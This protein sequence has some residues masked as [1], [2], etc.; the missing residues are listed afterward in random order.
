MLLSPDTDI[1]KKVFPDDTK[2][3]SDVKVK[4]EGLE[5]F[6]GGPAP[7]EIYLGRVQDRHKPKKQVLFW[8]LT[9][10]NMTSPDADKANLTWMGGQGQ[11]SFFGRAH[12]GLEQ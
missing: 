6:L 9:G 3:A 7:C 2:D 10:D 11:D 4:F 8:Q 1:I 5:E 12:R